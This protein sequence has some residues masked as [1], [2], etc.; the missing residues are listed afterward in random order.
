MATQ[1]HD[2]A[3]MMPSWWK[4]RLPTIWFSDVTGTG[5]ERPIMPGDVV[6]TH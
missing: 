5:L 2:P 6:L 4:V 3:I 1:A